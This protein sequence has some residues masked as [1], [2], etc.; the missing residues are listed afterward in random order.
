MV[1]V[2]GSR[3][4]R[5]F[6]RRKKLAPPVG[7]GVLAP[8]TRIPQRAAESNGSNHD[9]WG[10]RRYLTGIG[11]G[12]FNVRMEKTTDTA[13]M[14]PTTGMLHSTPQCSVARRTRYGLDKVELAKLTVPH[15]TCK[16]CWRR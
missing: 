15:P 4:P 5:P 9:Y 2:A 1:E 6:S 11:P 13:W 7:R 16:K 3:T 14:Q 8:L 12:W 10:I